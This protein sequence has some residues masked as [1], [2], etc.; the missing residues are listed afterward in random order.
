M[1]GKICRTDREDGKDGERM[2]IGRVNDG[3][4][5]MEKGWR[6]DGERMGKGWRKDGE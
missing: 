6:K 3:K 2:E 5:R 4:K 1:D